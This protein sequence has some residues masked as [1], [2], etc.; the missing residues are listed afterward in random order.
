MESIANGYEFYFFSYYQSM[1]FITDGY[2]YDSNEYTVPN[3]SLRC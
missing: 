3:R 1:N 2:E